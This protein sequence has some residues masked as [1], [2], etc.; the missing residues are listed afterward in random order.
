MRTL[1]AGTLAAFFSGILQVN[2]EA[3]LLLSDMDAAPVP[4]EVQSK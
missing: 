3:L 4:V 1:T 2:E